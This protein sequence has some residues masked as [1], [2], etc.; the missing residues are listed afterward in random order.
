MRYRPC[1]KETYLEFAYSYASVPTS[2]CSPDLEF[3]CGKKQVPLWLIA[4]VEHHNKL[5]L[6]P[7]FHQILL[8]LHPEHKR[9]KG[10]NVRIRD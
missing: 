4:C 3:L 9:R 5:K 1:H 6:D 8:N 7:V 2:Q 10:G